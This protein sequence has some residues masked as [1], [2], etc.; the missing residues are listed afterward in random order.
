MNRPL[1]SRY[2]IYEVIRLRTEN[3]KEEAQAI[4]A[5]ILLNASEFDLSHA[6]LE[7][8]RLDVPTIDDNEIYIAHSGEA[9]VDVSG[10]PM[11]LVMDRSRPFYITG[12]ETVIA[13]PFKGDSNF[14]DIQPQTYTLNLP[15]VEMGSSEL[16]LRYVRTDQDGEAIKREYQGTVRSIKEHLRSLSESAAQF[17]NQLEGLVSASP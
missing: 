1:F 15:C 9:K 7:K 17:N 2:P 12:T 4:P 13:V 5:N 14:F 10:D 8:L 3:V 6:I 16:L 11:R